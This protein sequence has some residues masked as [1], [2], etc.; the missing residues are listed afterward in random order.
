MST[1]T[2][3]DE[4]ALSHADDTF[5]RRANFCWV[6]A[7]GNDLP[8]TEEILLSRK[9]GDLL[10]GRSAPAK[11]DRL[12]VEWGAKDQWFRFDEI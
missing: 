8:A 5:L 9:N 12:N 11:C 10:R 3:K 2:R 6:D 4:W 1:G 7:N